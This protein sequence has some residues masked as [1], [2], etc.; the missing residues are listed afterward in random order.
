MTRRVDSDALGAI[1]RALGLTGAGSG[2]TE[3]FD[4]I[5]DQVLDVGSLVRRGRTQAATA[6]QYVGRM[7]NVHTDAEALATAVLPYD[8]VVGGNAPYPVPVSR[9]YDIW[10]LAAGTTRVS[11][12]GTFNGALSVTYPAVNAGF[13]VDDSSVAVAAAG[14]DVAVVTWNALFIEASLTSGVQAGSDTSG[15]IAIGTRLPRGSTLLFRST[16]SLTSTY[17]CQV[18]LGVFP[19]GLGQDVLV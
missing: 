1:N 18:I 2:E 14:V 3:F 6:G 13:G 4:G 15:L 17:E 16:S 9:R 7:R 10:L 11:G 12:S 8:V 5:L 19:A